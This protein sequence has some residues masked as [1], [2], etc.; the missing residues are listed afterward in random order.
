MTISSV[1]WDA[2]KF[3]T[4]ITIA[5]RKKQPDNANRKRCASEVLFA[6]HV[7]YS[8]LILLCF[9]PSLSDFFFNIL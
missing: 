2:Q 8:L 7:F 5:A 6:S 1:Y 3:H 4:Q 9:L